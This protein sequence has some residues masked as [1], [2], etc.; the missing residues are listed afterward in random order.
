[1]TRTRVAHLL[2]T[3]V[4][5]L[6]LLYPVTVGAQPDITCRGVT[7]GPGD[8]CAKADNSGV[9][10]YEQRTRTAHQAKPVIIGVGLLVV[11]FGTFLLVSDVRKRRPEAEAVA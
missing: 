8:T 11:A 2:V 7:M 4:G 6:I 5:L 3:L 10:T 9:Q 1:M